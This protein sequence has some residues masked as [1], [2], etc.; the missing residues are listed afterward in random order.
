ML[1]ALK[2]VPAGK[3]VYDRIVN[4]MKAA[5]NTTKQVSEDNDAE[6]IDPTVIQGDESK[7][8]ES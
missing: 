3:E 8:T 2:Q 4:G 7:S 6:V 1:E 5:A